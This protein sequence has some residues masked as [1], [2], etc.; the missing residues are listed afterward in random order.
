MC[1]ADAPVL[2]E[3]DSWVGR[4]LRSPDLTS[5]RFGELAELLTLL[6]RD[7]SQQILNLRYALPHESHDATS[8]FTNQ[9]MDLWGYHAGVQIAFL[10]PGKSEFCRTLAL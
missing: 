8:E 4:E 10:R 9:A 6:F 5:G 2:W 3:A 7:R 1:T